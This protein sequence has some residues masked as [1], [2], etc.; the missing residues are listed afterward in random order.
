VYQQFM[1][2]AH[3]VNHDGDKLGDMIMR[4]Y[5]EGVATSTS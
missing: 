4:S 5:L 1:V 3:A 2:D